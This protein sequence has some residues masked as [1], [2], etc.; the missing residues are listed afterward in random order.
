[1]LDTLD[2]TLRY[3]RTPCA[4]YHVRPLSLLQQD[5]MYRCD[6]RVTV[7][8]LADA[9]RYTHSEIRAVLAFLGQHGLIKTLPPDP[10]LF[11]SRPPASAAYP[12]RPVNGRSRG[13]WR[14]LKSR[15]AFAFPALSDVYFSYKR[16]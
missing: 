10:T 11:A 1:M 3:Q 9:T 14:A 4:K 6:G 13:F 12:S 16:R 5:I 2:F 8:D 15:T 7:A